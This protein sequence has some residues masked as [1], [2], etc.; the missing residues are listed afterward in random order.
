MVVHNREDRKFV[1]TLCG[2]RFN[3]LGALRYHE[4]THRQE[5]NHEC[6]VCKK[7]FLAKYDLTKH[8]RIHT[9]TSIIIVRVFV[10][11]IYQLI[12]IL[13]EKPYKCT[14]CDKRFTISK[15]AKVH[16]R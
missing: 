8:Y 16:M 15:N 10:N 14:Y 4:K 3:R 12:L 13:G 11:S 5:R 9:G 2:S 7:A 6:D 1:C